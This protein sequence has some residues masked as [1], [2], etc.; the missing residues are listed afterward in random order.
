ME[1]QST[2]QKIFGAF[3]ETITGKP[4]RYLVSQDECFG[5]E[6]VIVDLNNISLSHKCE[7]NEFNIPR[8]G[9]F[10]YEDVLIQPN[11]VFG[12]KRF[13][14]EPPLFKNKPISLFN[15]DRYDKLHGDQL[16]KMIK[17]H[18]TK[19]PYSDILYSGNTPISELKEQ[20]KFYKYQTQYSFSIYCPE[21]HLLVN[22]DLSS[23]NALFAN[24]EVKEEFPNIDPVLTNNITADEFKVLR[25]CMEN[26]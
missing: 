14:S 18:F 26:L 15:I 25:Y 2:L 9:T 19:R 20:Y 5:V 17:L 11:T 16:I 22:H 21:K 10:E 24:L 8:K 1:K 6:I 4:I 13:I 7:F 12:G 3:G 23:N